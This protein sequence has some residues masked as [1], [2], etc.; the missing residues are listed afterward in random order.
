MTYKELLSKGEN[1]LKQCD[2]P[3]YSIDAYIFMEIV[4]GM[5]R[6]VYYIKCNDTI[7]DEALIEQY[8]D[9]IEKRSKRIPLQHITNSQEFMGLSFY[10]DENVLCPRQD[11]ECLV[12][13]ALK[14]IDDNVDVL[15]MCTGS[16]CIAISIKKLCDK[17]NHMTAVDLS[18]EALRIAKKNADTHNTDVEFVHS[19]LFENLKDRKYDI[20]ISNPPYIRT[21]DIDE[22]MDEVKIHEPMMALDG[23][24]DGL[25]FYREITSKA[26]GYLRVGGWLMY[27]IGYDQ[28]E[29]V[30]AIMI[31]NG[32]DDIEIIKDLAGL[33]RIVKGRIIGG[34]Q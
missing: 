17:V 15:D 16:G 18:E 4:F 22:L 12:E 11:T 3:D 24:E 8:L 20:I 25:Y 32:F 19:N 23:Y 5:S 31:N 6:A 30:K 9:M 28:G 33:D 14:A 27:E 29:E 21:S 13:E 2:V 34:K 26:K 10:V 7:E 1:V